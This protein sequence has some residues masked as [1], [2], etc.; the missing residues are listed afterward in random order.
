VPPAAP[1][2][3]RGL[4]RYLAA[5]AAVL[6]VGPINQHVEVR[7]AIG[8]TGNVYQITVVDGVDTGCTCPS[9]EYRGGPCKHMG[10]AAVQ[11]VRSGSV[12]Y[13]PAYHARRVELNR[14]HQAQV[15]QGQLYWA[16]RA[17]WDASDRVRQIRKSRAFSAIGRELG[18]TFPGLALLASDL[19]KVGRALVRYSQWGDRQ[20]EKYRE[21]RTERAE[22]QAADW[23]AAPTGQIKHAEPQGGK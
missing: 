18:A 20:V 19:A 12:G 21:W 13:G 15:A 14:E 9:F 4:V 23:K 5:L 16:R 10:S 8:S 6:E 3:V 7:E 1:L 11:P 17:A 22:K 2:E